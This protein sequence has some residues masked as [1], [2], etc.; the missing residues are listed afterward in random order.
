ML[1]G[2][3]NTFDWD[4]LR[5]T[6]DAVGAGDR[7]ARARGLTAKRR[8]SDRLATMQQSRPWWHKAALVLVL[9]CLAAPF[10]AR[11][12]AGPPGGR[13]HV[14]W[15]ASVDTGTRQ[16][17]EAQYRLA[18]P[19]QL[20]DR[21]WRYDL[22]D[23]RTDTIRAIVN[24]PAVADTHDINRDGYALD[25]AAVRTSRRQRFAAG[26]AMVAAADALSVISAVAG[27]A[28]GR[29]RPCRP[30]TDGRLD[31]GLRRRPRAIDS[32]CCCR[33]RGA[34]GAMAAAR[35]PRCGCEHGRHLPGV[36]RPGGADVLPGLPGRLHASGAFVRFSDRRTA[37]RGGH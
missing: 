12:L 4:N 7:S 31:V 1:E 5:F 26:D 10:A 11:L 36:V 25:P 29:H 24:D 34:A 13:V 16:R 19:E 28:A 9:F 35:H 22:I 27:V 21:T 32:T 15:Q 20:D 8:A 30:W 18:D 6:I 14:R 2:D 37:A 17:L 3:L 33:P 23:P